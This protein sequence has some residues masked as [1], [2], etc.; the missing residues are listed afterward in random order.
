MRSDD[1]NESNLTI[2]EYNR[3]HAQIIQWCS[4]CSSRHRCFTIG[5]RFQQS[6]VIRPRIRL[7]HRARAITNV[8]K[9]VS[10][11]ARAGKTSDGGW[12]TCVMFLPA[13]TGDPGPLSTPP[14]GQTPANLPAANG[15]QTRA[16]TT[17]A[18]RRGLNRPGTDAACTPRPWADT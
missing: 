9:Y 16:L 5:N 18:C 14:S 2:I 12:H 15:P 11:N 17:H 10:M 6:S 3:C 1:S 8:L 7:H 4:Q 13:T